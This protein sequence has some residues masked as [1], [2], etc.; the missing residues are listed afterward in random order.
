[1]SDMN[2]FD[3]QVEAGETKGLTRRS[4][5][6]AAAVAGAAA[7][8]IGGPVA[9]AFAADPTASQIAWD[10]EADVLVIGSGPAGMAC[11][12]TAA[13]QGASV[14]VLEANDKIGGKG[15]LAGG[16]LGIG[17]GTRMQAAAHAA[18]LPGEPSFVETADIIYQD[19][20]IEAFRTDGVIGASAG[21]PETPQQMTVGDVVGGKHTVTQWRKIS[22]ANDAEGMARVF[23]DSSLDTWNW[24]DN[25]GAP[26]IQANLSTYDLVYRGSRYYTTTKPT[27]VDRTNPTGMNA[28]GAGIIWAMYDEAIKNNAQVLVSHKMT[29]LI[30]EGDRSGRVIG[31]EVFD[32]VKNQTLHFKARKAVFLGT[33]SWNGS[34]KIKVLFTPWLKAYPHISGQPYVMNDGSGIE[35][36]IEAGASHHHRPRLGLARL[37]P[38]PRHHLALH[39]GALR[40]P[41]RGRPEA[42]AG[43]LRERAR[44]ALHQRRD[45]REQPGLGRRQPAVL[46]RAG[47]GHADHRRRWAHRLDHHG[48]RAARG[49]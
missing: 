41:G 1:M 48:R 42:G 47:G 29:K 7:G 12:A 44:Q 39:L 13:E 26:F 31:V 40:R 30:R 20:T 34:Q 16:N 18:A 25:L 37:A 32:S 35:I 24:L 21:A 27:P 46:L 10:Q 43:H 3:G 4:F 28:G 38:S 45:Q 33:G 8:L 5:L 19:R 23:A 15:I 2:D 14:I 6:G 17:G 9:N 11:A 22:G 36:A 49:A